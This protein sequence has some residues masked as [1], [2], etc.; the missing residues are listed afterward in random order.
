MSRPNIL[1]IM[2]DQHRWDYMGYMGQPTM[3]GLTP[4]F[5]RLASEGAAF[6]RCYSVN[7]L[8]MPARNAVHTG[9]YTFQS[10][11]MDNVGDWPMNVPTFTQALQKLGYHTSLTGKL[12]RALAVVGLQS[13]H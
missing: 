1:F 6:T 4:H 12:R 5:D 10:G 2:T 3:R 7:P 11:Q 9:L 8:C 13:D